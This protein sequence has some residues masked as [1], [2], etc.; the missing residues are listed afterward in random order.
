MILKE[1]HAP[2]SDEPQL[3]VGIG[4]AFDVLIWNLERN[5]VIRVGSKENILKLFVYGLDF[6]FE[7]RHESMPGLDAVVNVRILDY[8][9]ETELSAV[10][11]SCLGHLV[12]WSTYTIDF[13]LLDRRHNLRLAVRDC[14]KHHGEERQARNM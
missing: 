3:R 4:G 9:R 14:G 6:L 8:E 1:Q 7:R 10:W 13:S 2:A 5:G 12:C 11:I